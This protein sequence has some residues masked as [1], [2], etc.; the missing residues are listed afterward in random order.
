[1]NPIHGKALDRYIMNTKSSPME[2]YWLA[3]KKTLAEKDLAS[4]ID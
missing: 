1:M 4:I 3:G 2:S